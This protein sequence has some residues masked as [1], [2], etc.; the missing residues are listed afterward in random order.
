[1]LFKEKEKPLHLKYFYGLIVK[2]CERWKYNHVVKSSVAKVEEIRD[3][4]QGSECSDR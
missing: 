2:R 4:K 3:S 1:M